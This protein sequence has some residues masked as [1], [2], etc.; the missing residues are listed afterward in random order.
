[1]IPPRPL[2][3]TGFFP[4]FTHLW[5][6][7]RPRTA[8]PPPGNGSRIASACCGTLLHSLF[9]LL[10]FLFQ[11]VLFYS[12]CLC[13]FLPHKKCQT[14]MMTSRG[15]EK[16]GEGGACKEG[17][18][19]LDGLGEAGGGGNSLTVQKTVVGGEGR[20]KE[21]KEGTCVF[22]R[23]FS[24]SAASGGG[25]RKW[26]KRKRLFSLPPSLPLPFRFRRTAEDERD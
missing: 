25:C 20:K 21:G 8:T 17:E 5:C 26:T 4:F 22:S 12:I 13:V 6:R 24:S 3:S 19:L 9:G 2:L 15:L 14:R 23:P 16:G 7:K 1:M 11:L 10:Y 18:G